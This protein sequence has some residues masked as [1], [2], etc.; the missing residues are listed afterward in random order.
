MEMNTSKT[1]IREIKQMAKKNLQSIYSFPK[2]IN[3]LGIIAIKDPKKRQ[4]VSEGIA[5]I[6][7]GAVVIGGENT[8]IANIITVEKVSQN[9]LVGFDFFVFDNEYEGVDV[10]QYMKAGITPIMPEQNVFSG[11]LQEFNPMKFEG[12]G[13]FWNSDNPYCIFQKVVA[14]TE[15][16]KFP[17]DRRVLLKNITTTF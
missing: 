10:I 16:I 17:E 8:D 14:Y 6:G 5:A 9:D 2:A 15:N 12:N 3:S 11:M 13:F 7:L 1:S 4:F